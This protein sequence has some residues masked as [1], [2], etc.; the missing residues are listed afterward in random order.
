M[1]YQ[2]NREE[3]HD[4]GGNIDNYKQNVD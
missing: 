1:I 3:K 4:N 2:N